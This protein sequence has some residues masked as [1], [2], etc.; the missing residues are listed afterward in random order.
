MPVWPGAWLTLTVEAH[1]S[2]LGH[3]LRHVTAVMPLQLRTQPHLGC[4]LASAVAAASALFMHVRAVSLHLLL[5]TVRCSM[6][7]TSDVQAAVMELAVR[8]QLS[9]R[10]GEAWFAHPL[11][12]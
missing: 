6:R 5:D 1:L 10:E 4:C 9:Q 2:S 12:F 3:V 8:S 7:L 11:H